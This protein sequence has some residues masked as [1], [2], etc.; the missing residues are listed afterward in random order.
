M[1]LRIEDNSLRLR[2]SDLEVQQLAS[3]GT[4]SSKVSFPKGKALYYIINTHSG[5][6]FEASLQNDGIRISIPN[7]LCQKWAHSEQI[8]LKGSC[9]VDDGVELSILVEKDL[10]CRHQEDEEG[11]VIQRGI[12][13]TSTV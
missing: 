10:G 11:K 3:D 12:R 7:N 2:L 1:K 6:S 8:G 9:L 4:L 5:I 13:D